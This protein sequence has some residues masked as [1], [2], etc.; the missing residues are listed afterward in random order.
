MVSKV[1]VIRQTVLLSISISV[2]PLIL[3]PATF[4]IPHF[5]LHP[6]YAFAEWALYFLIY[7]AILPTLSMQRKVV[8]GGVTVIFRLAV[9]LVLG[10]LVSLMHGL[11]LAAAVPFCT[12]EYPPALLLHIIFAPFLLRPLFGQAWARGIRFA[13]DSGRQSA[14]GEQARG[15]SFSSPL[16]APPPTHPR[17]EIGELSFDAA[18]AWIGEYSGVR[19]SLVVDNDGLVVSRW[20][21]QVYSRD[22]EFWAA[23]AVEMTRFHR[24]W[25]AADEP[26]DL[27]RLEVETTSGRLTIRQA[28]PFWLV[29]LTE[30]DTGELV[31][32]RLVQAIEMIEKHYRDRYRTVCPAGREVSHV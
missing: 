31:S 12:W 28:G 26:I 27:R 8:A 20:A 18:T 1:A 7:L 5:S 2:F 13:I 25:P 17:A 6:L 23:V 15:F 4:G 14:P 3:Y 9:G 32:V 29:I 24:R 22:A 16:A 30:A 21:R 19:M 10:G 11:P